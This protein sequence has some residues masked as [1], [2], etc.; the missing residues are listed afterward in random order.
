MEHLALPAAPTILGV[1]VVILV[2]LR[3]LLLDRS[4]FKEMKRE[5][6]DVRSAADG[7]DRRVAVCEASWAEQ[8]SL[9]HQ[10]LNDLT[11]AEMFLHIVN[12]LM[13]NCTCKALDVL[14]PMIPE[15]LKTIA[16]REQA[17]VVATAVHEATTADLKGTR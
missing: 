10:A 12:D 7:L 4:A 3:S 8:R 15:Y 1:V 9:K 5:L 6:D 17:R 16:V 14:H 2:I 13:T 11:R